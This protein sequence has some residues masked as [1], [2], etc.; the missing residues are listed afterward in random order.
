MLERR[1]GPRWERVGADGEPKDLVLAGE[2]LVRR[3]YGS[4]SIVWYDSLAPPWSGG[5]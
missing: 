2:H 5:R 4:R 1:L 3:T